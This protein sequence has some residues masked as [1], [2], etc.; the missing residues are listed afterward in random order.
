MP[1][2]K[3]IYRS[4]KESIETE[5]WSLSG[6]SK[7]NLLKTPQIRILNLKFYWDR[8]RSFE[9]VAYNTRWFKYDRDKL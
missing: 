8:K 7:P 3:S 2:E 9:M 1:A 5:R 6:N 4:A